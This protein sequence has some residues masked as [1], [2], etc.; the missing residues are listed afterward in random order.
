MDFIAPIVEDKT[1]DKVTFQYVASHDNWIENRNSEGLC[2]S[3]TV[4]VHGWTS[5]YQP[6]SKTSYH[7][8]IEGP[9]HSHNSLYVSDPFTVVLPEELQTNATFHNHDHDNMD[10]TNNQNYSA[11]KR[12]WN[13][14]VKESPAYA[15]AIEQVK[16]Q[17]E[18]L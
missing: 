18:A 17:L 16:A 14:L 7:E 10:L 2:L 5:D 13:K 9:D 15:A 3:L 1:I 6:P 11:A 12:E 4:R 8:G